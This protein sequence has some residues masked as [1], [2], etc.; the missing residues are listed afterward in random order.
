[1]NKISLSREIDELKN[2]LAY[3]KNMGFFFGAGTSCALGIPS[4]VELTG[5]IEQ[6][7]S[8]DDK[9][10]FDV[11]KSDLPGI[12][13]G[14]PASIE[15][16]LNQ[17]RR[18]R[19]ITDDREDRDYQTVSG[20]AAK[21]LDT[22]ICSLVYKLILEKE[23]VA[24]TNITKK[25]FAWLNIQNRD[26]SKEI[27]TT[28]YDL[29]IEKSLEASRIPY[30][31]SFVGAYEPFFWQESV[32]KVATD[33][34]LTRNWIR[35]W[36]LHGSLS[37][38]WNGKN[39]VRA[40]KVEDISK[41]EKELV[42]YPSREKYDA[43]RKLPFVSYFD[44]LKNYLSEGEL[45]FFFT[46]YSFLD[47]HINEIVFNALRENSRLSALIFFFKDDEVRNLQ[48]SISAYMNLR[49]FGPTLAIINGNIVEWDF[50]EKDQFKAD[51]KTTD[52]FW[53]ESNNSLTLGDFNALVNFLIINS[54]RKDAIEA[55]LK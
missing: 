35:L 12:T 13:T 6:S 44:R 15:D 53:N 19:E 9:K 42:I 22:K 54:G 52:H 40:G 37:W 50:S 47:Q 17:A 46:G 51:G 16:I 48:T 45:L 5:L 14:R 11:I 26:F 36:K 27:F 18:I 8:G 10:C 4:V 31:D 34:D 49:V 1:M 38:F 55:T 33:G 3:S 41:I 7:M 23:A 32:D 30:F 39:I 29:V 20:K 25:F 24:D 28:N 2:Q 21:A 43:S